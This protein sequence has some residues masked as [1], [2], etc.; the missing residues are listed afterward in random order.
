MTVILTIAGTG[1][2]MQKRTQKPVEE[3]AEE[4]EEHNPDPHTHR[5]SIELELQEEGR[6]EE[7][8]QLG[9]PNP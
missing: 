2:V 6:S 8:E 7:G 1:R 4:V 9:Q 5:E 3:V